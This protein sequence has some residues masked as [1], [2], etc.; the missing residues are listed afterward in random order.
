[1]APSFAT[2]VPD[3]GAPN[4]AFAAVEEALFVPALTAAAAAGAAALE[5]D[6]V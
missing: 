3:A 4:F 1:L 5:V 6:V 2:S